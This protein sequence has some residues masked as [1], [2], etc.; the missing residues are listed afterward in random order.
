MMSYRFIFLILLV[1]SN[2]VLAADEIR[3]PENA[4]RPLKIGVA[5]TVNTISKINEEAGTIEA[6]VDLQLRWK[7]AGLA[8]NPQ[9]TGMNRLEFNN[10][11]A[12]NKLK[13]VWTPAL[14]LANATIHH[15]KQVLFIYADGTVLLIQRVKGVFD[16]KF[17]LE[18]F[19]FD[20]ESFTVRIVS[21]R[22]NTNQI[23]LTHNQY[24]INDSGLRNG[25]KIS[26]WKPEQLNFTSL[27][28]QGWDGRYYPE[29]Q[30]NIIVTRDPQGHLLLILMPFFLVTLLPTFAM[31][32]TKIPLQFQLNYT[33]GAILSLIAL[34]F[35]YKVRYPALT[36]DSIIVQLILIGAIY[37]SA[38]LLLNI[39]LFNR[40]QSNTLFS[41]RF[42]TEEIISYLK[43]AMP[44]ALL[45]L[46]LSRVMLTALIV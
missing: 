37:I 9:E 20:T 23:E 32:Y 28:T 38:I 27:S 3:M 18:A 11:F 5:M 39:T 22:Y 10:E 29:T 4:P 2:S 26:G 19:P 41:N 25:I 42:I 21:E 14:T 36:S 16:V 7:D 46:V 34:T 40:E 45:G 12:E 35:T 44:L 31:L 1:L 6:N 15:K 30:A 8:F 13:D 33:G 43:W 17:K 24:D